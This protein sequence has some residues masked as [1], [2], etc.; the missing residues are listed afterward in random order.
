[1]LSTFSFSE[2]LEESRPRKERVLVRLVVKIDE[3]QSAVRT[4]SGSSGVSFTGNQR[5]GL[6]LACT[7]L[8]ELNSNFPKYPS[9]TAELRFQHQEGQK[10]LTYIQELNSSKRSVYL[11]NRIKPRAWLLP[12]VLSI[13]LCSVTD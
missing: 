13:T 3:V 5:S 7:F 11:Q 4:E 1:M 8:H 12:R 10:T 6:K 9:V 2:F